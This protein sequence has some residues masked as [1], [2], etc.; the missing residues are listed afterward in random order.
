M[1]ALIIAAVRVSFHA[2]VDAELSDWMASWTSVRG[3]LVR[4][5]DGSNVALIVAASSFASVAGTLE[6][7]RTRT[8]KVAFEGSSDARRISIG[9][10]TE[11]S[12][13]VSSPA[14]E[15]VV[16]KKATNKCPTHQRQTALTRPLAL[17]HC[18]ISLRRVSRRSCARRVAWKWSWWK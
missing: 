17:I 9:P 3:F 6:S 18:R 2:D 4:I 12:A 5:N 1:L 14:T 16:V 15:S 10:E 8:S 7:G 11:A 13:Q